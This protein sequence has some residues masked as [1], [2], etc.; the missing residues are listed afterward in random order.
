MANDQSSSNFP[1]NAAILAAIA[2]AG[3]LFMY[4]DAPL[5]GVRPEL[6]EAQPR[7]SGWS[8]EKVEA[9]LWQDPMAA[10]AKVDEEDNSGKSPSGGISKCDHNLSIKLNEKISVIGVMIPGGAYSE[11]NEV[12]RRTRY[13]VLSGLERSSGSNLTLGALV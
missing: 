8:E 11:M 5:Q 12:R 13:A 4:R 1:G 6:T 10:V 9:R 7:D 2:L 3:G